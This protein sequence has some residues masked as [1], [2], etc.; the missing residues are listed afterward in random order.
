MTESH[1]DIYQ[2]ELLAT[3]R[4]FQAGMDLGLP[5]AIARAWSEGCIVS[6]RALARELGSDACRTYPTT[7]LRKLSR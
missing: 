5:E 6:A 7:N 4:I 2:R 3:A 1:P